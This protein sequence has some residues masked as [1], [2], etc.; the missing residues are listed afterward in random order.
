MSEV[1]DSKPI[2]LTHRPIWLLLIGGLAFGLVMAVLT[3]L[4]AGG[5]PRGS[6]AG[7]VT[8][9]PDK[10]SVGQPAPEFTALTSDGKSLQLSD[11]RGSPIAVNFWAT[12]CAPCK[13]EMP[14]L[15]SAQVRYSKEKFI[16]LGVNAGDTAE[17]VQT[18]MR[19][20]KLTFI[21]V[22]DPDSTIIDLFGIRAFPTTIWIDRDGIVRAKHIGE[23]TRETID[24]YVADLLKR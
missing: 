16:V 2:M 7:P 14:E 1:H 22:L 15:Q 12:W 11:Y 4:W 20:L 24:R 9:I 5:S 18:Y 23:L 13:V 17:Q 19:D 10:V 6:G 8:P 21:S 3:V